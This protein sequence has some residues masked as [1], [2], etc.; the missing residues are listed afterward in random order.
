VSILWWLG[1]TAIATWVAQPGPATG[2]LPSAAR[3]R[4]AQRRRAR[5]QG[6][7]LVFILTACAATLF[8][9]I[10]VLSVGSADTSRGLQKEFEA[11]I[12]AVIGGTLLTGGYG[13]AIGAMFGSLIFGTV[14]MGIFY[15]GI[16]T[17]WFKAFMGTMLLIA[18]LFNN[19]VR[20][21][22]T[23]AR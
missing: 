12:A 16:D 9:A 20:K 3:E 14:Q 6:E 5:G 18:V 23:E 21:R 2:S 10:Q 17:D 7:N 15:T 19:Y 22:A 4:R 11:I 8:A 1:L 13:S